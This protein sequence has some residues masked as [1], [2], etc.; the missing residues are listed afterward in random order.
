MH[1]WC[2]RPV[3]LQESNRVLFQQKKGMNGKLV[4]VFKTQ[5]RR[6]SKSTWICSPRQ[7]VLHSAATDGRHMELTQR[8]L[9]AVRR[10]LGSAIRRRSLPHWH[11]N[12]QRSAHLVTFVFT[13]PL[14][15]LS[16]LHYFI[17]LRLLAPGP[18]GNNRSHCATADCILHNQYHPPQ[19]LG[20]C[21]LLLS[22][23]PGS[24]LNCIFRLQYDGST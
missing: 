18:Q 8:P 9:P 17:C 20:C 3:Q 4:N 12:L 7:E 15:S 22:R 21:C 2:P 16:P 11:A 10:G 13:A 1:L 24:C 14:L 19:K 5:R 6:Q 23:L